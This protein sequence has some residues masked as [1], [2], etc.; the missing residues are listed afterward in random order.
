MS[1]F[2]FQDF[3]TG[4]VSLLLFCTGIVGIK[5]AYMRYIENRRSQ[6][7]SLANSRQ[8]SPLNSNRN[9]NIVSP[10]EPPLY[11]LLDHDQYCNKITSDDQNLK[12][13]YKT[14]DLPSY[15]QVTLSLQTKT[16]KFKNSLN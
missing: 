2:V 10:L 15:D 13:E 3:L 16:A 5:Y 6:R 9:S 8:S 11:H 4:L 12:N 7:P 1:K 14:N